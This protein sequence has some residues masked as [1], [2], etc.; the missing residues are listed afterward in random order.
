MSQEVQTGNGHSASWHM[1]YACGRNAYKP[2]TSL[3]MSYTHLRE[4]AFK[5][6]QTASISVKVE[7]E[8]FNKGYLAGYECARKEWREQ[9]HGN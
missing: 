1:G 3:S 9:R 8:Q 7:F 4:L 5:A 2:E 6:W